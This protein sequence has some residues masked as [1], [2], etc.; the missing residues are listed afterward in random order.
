LGSGLAQLT[1]TAF[2]R[3]AAEGR[4]LTDGVG[5]VALNSSCQKGKSGSS[6]TIWR[7]EVD[8]PVPS[9]TLSLWTISQ[10]SI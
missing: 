9:S 10:E 3:L 5:R 2:D 1:G 7:S 4:R 8:T 6:A